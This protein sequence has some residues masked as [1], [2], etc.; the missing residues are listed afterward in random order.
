MKGRRLVA[1][2]GVDDAMLKSAN[3]DEESATAVA[4]HGPCLT[5]NEAAILARDSSSRITMPFKH[6]ARFRA[7]PV[8]LSIVPPCLALLKGGNSAAMT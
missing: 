1:Q 4:W 6:Y 2:R 7:S 5:A 8:F 3:V